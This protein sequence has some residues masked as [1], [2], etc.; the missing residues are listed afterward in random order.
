MKLQKLLKQDMKNEPELANVVFRSS[1]DDLKDLF[2][3]D[4]IRSICVEANGLATSVGILS[5]A[6]GSV[7]WIAGDIVEEEVISTA[8]NGHGYAASAQ[9]AWA[10]RTDVDPNNYLVGTIDRLNAASRATA[11][12]V[13][14][15]AVLNY[16]FMPL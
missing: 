8:F 13:G 9:I 2:N 10:N 12:K 3:N 7:N 15:A 4:Q 14:R 5:I 11:T 16:V 6:P 1:H